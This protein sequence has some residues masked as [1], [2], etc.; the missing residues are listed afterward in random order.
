MVGQSA[1]AQLESAM[2]ENESPEELETDEEALEYDE[3][4][5]SEEVREQLYAEFNQ[6]IALERFQAERPDLW[7]QAQRTGKL[8]DL[9]QDMQDGI[10]PEGSCFC[11]ANL[12]VYNAFAVRQVLEIDLDACQ[13]ILEIYGDGDLKNGTVILPLEAISWFGFPKEAVPLQFTF[14]GFISRRKPSQTSQPS[15]VNPQNL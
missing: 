8:M 12:P 2:S 5:I 1:P 13:V 4:E 15:P 6:E 9:Q 10:F 11:Y 7:L 14:Q 3:S